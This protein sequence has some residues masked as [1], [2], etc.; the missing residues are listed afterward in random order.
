MALGEGRGC[1]N[2]PGA[3]ILSSVR[4][5][6]EKSTRNIA[7]DAGRIDFLLEYVSGSDLMPG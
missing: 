7:S 3:T 1:D 5:R 4:D 6:L 2:L